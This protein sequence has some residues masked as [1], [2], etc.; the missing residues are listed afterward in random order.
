[1]APATAPEQSECTLWCDLP[2]DEFIVLIAGY[3]KQDAVSFFAAPKLQQRTAVSGKDLEG[4]AAVSLL[5]PSHPS[6]SQQ[7][8]Y[9][10]D[11]CVQ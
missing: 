1:M 10:Y 7:R 6:T 9:G 4:L 5:P 3:A 11:F 8:L 2:Q